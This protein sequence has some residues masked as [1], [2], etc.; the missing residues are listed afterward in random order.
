MLW[1]SCPMRVT[2]GGRA[3]YPDAR[4]KLTVA[5]RRA[6]GGSGS[7]SLCSLHD[8]GMVLAQPAQTSMPACCADE[9]VFCKTSNRMYYWRPFQHAGQYVQFAAIL[10]RSDVGSMTQVLTHRGL[11]AVAHAT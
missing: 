11:A 3:R 4:L 6:G 10:R 8:F 9:L 1:G 2:A 5:V 7:D